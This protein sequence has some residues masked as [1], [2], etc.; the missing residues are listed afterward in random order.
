MARITKI[1]DKKKKL[2]GQNRFIKNSPNTKP[3]TKLWPAQRDLRGPGRAFHKAAGKL[4]VSARVLT[5][6]DRFQWFELCYLYQQ[7]TELKEIIRK[8][9]YVVTGSVG[10]KKNPAM[11]LYN[12]AF[13]N[14]QKLS[15][16]FG[17]SPL[18]RKKIDLPVDSNP[19]DPV[20]RFIFGN[21]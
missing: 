7:M 16:K 5:E 18:D 8:E 3:I 19:D 1:S 15:E 13:T 4:L 2:Q 21:K 11:Q 20:R 10:V 12:T 14:F 9:G 17:F 6:I